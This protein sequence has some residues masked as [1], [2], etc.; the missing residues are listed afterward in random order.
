MSLPSVQSH[1]SHSHH[2]QCKPSRSFAQLLPLHF[3][4]N[5]MASL[6]NLS[7]GSNYHFISPVKKN[8]KRKLVDS[9]ANIYIEDKSS[10]DAKYYRCQRN[11]NELCAGRGILRAGYFEVTR[12]H[13]VHIGDGVRAETQKMRS[14]L[15]KA[16]V[17]NKYAP[18][19]AIIQEVTSGLSAEAIVSLPSELAMKR[20]VQRARNKLHGETKAAKSLR[21]LVVPDCVKLTRKGD[22]FLWHDSYDDDT[23][24]SRIVVFTTRNFLEV[25]EFCKICVCEQAHYVIYALQL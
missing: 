3:S 20:D 5:V 17:E 10:S 21:E 16:S 9:S 13:S 22:P 11:R 2:H 7:S 1:S 23:S 24:L 15:Y 25:L 12:N 14:R 8:G 4:V 19:S 18:P 6:E